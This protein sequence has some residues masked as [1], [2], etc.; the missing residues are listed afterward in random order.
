M[1]LL[2]NRFYTV[3]QTRSGKGI[4]LGL[5]IAKGLMHKMSGD[6]SAEFK[7]GKLYMKCEWKVK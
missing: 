6:L 4:G 7:K 1:N 5:S 2:F 3:D